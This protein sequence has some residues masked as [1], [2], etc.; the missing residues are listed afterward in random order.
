[1]G[2]ENDGSN[3]AV[4]LASEEPTLSLPADKEGKDQDKAEVNEDESVFTPFFIGNHV[5]DRGMSC[6][7]LL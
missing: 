6:V 2:E 3:E 7:Y 5:P 1:M 4:G